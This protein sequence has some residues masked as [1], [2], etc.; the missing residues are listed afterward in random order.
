[1]KT[2]WRELARCGLVSCGVQEVRWNSRRLFCS[3]CERKLKSA[4]GR[5]FVRERIVKA[6][7]RVLFVSYSVSLSDEKSVENAHVSSEDRLRWSSG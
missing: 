7:N 3:E 2:V 6:G 5:I 1:V 4:L